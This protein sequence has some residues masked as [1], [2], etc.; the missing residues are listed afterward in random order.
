MLYLIATYFCLLILSVLISTLLGYFLIWVVKRSIIFNF[1]YLFFS[2]LIGTTALI[3]LFAIWHTNGITIMSF[4]LL[5]ALFQWAEYSRNAKNSKKTINFTYSSPFFVPPVLFL[6]L[7]TLF[8]YS[9]WGFIRPDSFIPFSIP[10]SHPSAA[11]DI[12]FQSH[13]P[14]FMTLTGQE[15]EFHVLNTLDNAYHGAKPYHYF[16]LW[17]TAILIGFTK[18]PSI[19]CLHFV[20]SVFINWIAYL[21]FLA[22][23]EQF[24]KVNWAK[25]LFT[26][27]F[28]FTGGFFFDFY[29]QLSWLQPAYVYQQSLLL[30]EP[31]LAYVYFFGMA[32]FILALRNYHVVGILCLLQM[33]IATALSLPSIL[34]SCVLVSIVSLLWKY[35]LTRKNAKSLFAYTILIAFG[36]LLFYNFFDVSSI[37]REGTKINS[38]SEL[39]EKLVFLNSP[40]LGFN[41]LVGTPILTFILYFPYI[42]IIILFYKKIITFLQ[43]Y[44]LDLL[45]TQ[46]LAIALCGVISWIIFYYQLNSLQLYYNTTIHLINVL[47]C[48]FVIAIFSRFDKKELWKYSIVFCLFVANT[49]QMLVFAAEEYP[50]RSNPTIYGNQYLEKIQNYLTK[51]NS[52][53]VVLGLSVKG[54]ED[55]VATFDSYVTIYANGYYL[56]YMRNGAITV[57]ITDFDVP[58][59]DANDM[60]KKRAEAGVKMGGFYQFVKRQKQNK[61]FE[62]IAQSQLDFVQKHKPKFTIVS[63]KAIL[64]TTLQPLVKEEWID[65]LS[66]EKFYIFDYQ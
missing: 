33:S 49:T 29:N 44:H 60:I 45:V 15:N 7:F 66:G 58:I 3:T 17:L 19:F 59:D 13:L 62:N 31:K 25:A 39:K 10:S 23:W 8:L 54:K 27:L 30:Y 40:K 1:T 12:I 56:P 51:F 2:A 16:E 21:G 14:Y 20:T 24:G 6:A 53:K 50:F 43:I 55:F 32:F 35:P 37:Q 9:C 63:P 52:S 11:R 28:L 5:L 36:V 48:T 22:I 64:P 34:L 61:Q 38:F 26:Y 46:V 65:E 41:L 18:L 47:L 4:F 57:S 42:L